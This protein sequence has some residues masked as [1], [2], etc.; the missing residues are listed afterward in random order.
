MNP[1]QLFLAFCLAYGVHSTSIHIGHRQG[2]G[3]TEIIA[4]HSSYTNFGPLE[5]LMQPI[6]SMLQKTT[7]MAC[8]RTR[9]CTHEILHKSP[10]TEILGPYQYHESHKSIFSVMEDLNPVHVLST[11]VKDFIAGIAKAEGDIV[12]APLKPFMDFGKMFMG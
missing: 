7:V 6:R 5:P 10:F 12:L 2:H 4:Q 3:G 11:A 1:L 9:L 8:D